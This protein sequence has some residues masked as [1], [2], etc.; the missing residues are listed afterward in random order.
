MST[1]RESSLVNFRALQ[2][3]RSRDRRGEL[4]KNVTELLGLVSD[5]RTPDLLDV[6]DSVM[7]RLADMAD[8]RARAGIALQ[9]AHM[10]AAPN[11]IVRKLALDEIEIAHPLL[12]CSPALTDDDLLGIIALRGSA[13]RR[14]IATRPGLS[15]AVA[16][17]LIRRGDDGTRRTLASNYTAHLSSETF[18]LLLDQARKDRDMQELLAAHPAAPSS[19]LRALAEFA[20]PHVAEKIRACLVASELAGAVARLFPK[21]RPGPKR[22]TS[23][24]KRKG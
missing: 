16:R 5:Q 20:D 18:D 24:R 23:R 2:H 4:L 13:H 10:R 8:S 7:V 1:M 6:Y 3:E 11:G 22:N 15:D 12:V 21:K 19:V 9:L 14:A 17:V